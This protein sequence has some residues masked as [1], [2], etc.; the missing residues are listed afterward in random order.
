MRQGLA[1]KQMNAPPEDQLIDDLI[2]SYG[3]L[4]EPE[5]P[6]YSCDLEVI[7]VEQIGEKL[8]AKINHTIIQCEE[9]AAGS[10]V[11]IAG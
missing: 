1:I 10:I 5:P 7:S 3:D 4:W 6:L 9:I 2:E 8:I 11:H